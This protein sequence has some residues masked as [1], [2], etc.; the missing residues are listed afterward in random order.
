[1][2]FAPAGDLAT[3]SLS[4][5][6]RPAIEVLLLFGGLAIVALAGW[7]LSRSM[8]HALA[9]LVTIAAAM[10]VANAVAPSLLGRELNLYWDLQH[11]PHLLP[12]FL[13]VASVRQIAIGIPLVVLTIAAVLFAVTASLK[14]L[15]DL[16]RA[17][18]GSAAAL[19]GAA[20]LAL[21]SAALPSAPVSGRL[22]R[23]LDH[24]LHRLAASWDIAHGRGA[25]Y[26]GLLGAEPGAAADLARLH[27]RDV[28]LVFF[29][30][31]GAVVFDDPGFRAEIAPALRQFETGLAAAGFTLRSGLIGSPTYG[32]GSW[33]AHG[34]L[35]SGSRLGD[36][37]LYDLMQMSGRPALP[38]RMAAA[39]YHTVNVMPGIKKPWPEGA[40]WGF[41]E[42]LYASSLGYQ[43]PSFGWFEIPD[44]FTLGSAAA[45]RR[46]SA[47]APVFMQVVLVSSHTPFHPVPPYLP[48]WEDAGRFATAAGVDALVRSQPDWSHLEVPYVQSIIYDLKVLQEW[49]A[50]LVPD[51]S[52]VIILGDHQPPAFV[53]G[54]RHSW[55]VPIHIASRDPEL[56][57]L[58][59]G[60]DFSDG[61]FPT[62]SVGGMEGFLQRFLEA[63]SAPVRPA[64]DANMA[65]GEGGTHPAAR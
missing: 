55:N 24:Q 37:T 7:T 60:P 3:Q 51:Q 53:G 25:A 41:D 59:A 58:L 47:A 49:M 33:L 34:T 39:G 13:D 12:L 18:R 6:W 16:F 52:L 31:Y 43:G 45:A 48:S 62:A 44:Q 64:G 23:S 17:H 57:R 1:M 4:L 36:Q 22:S 40:F 56:V 26:L 46:R 30:S 28:Y 11:V 32:G 27:G 54:I 63:Y 10:Q 5:E 61:A 9:V 19:A 20:M 38:R 65:A 50:Q 21:A 35:V 8:R 29:E 15:N 42:P 2:A 14:A